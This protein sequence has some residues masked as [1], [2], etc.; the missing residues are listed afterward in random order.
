MYVAKIQG[1]YYLKRKP[2]TGHTHDP[3]CDSFAMP[4]ELS[5][6]GQV[7]GKAITTDDSGETTL[8]LDFPLSVRG[9]RGVAPD[10]GDH[11]PTVAETSPSKLGLLREIGD[12]LVFARL[13]PNG[14]LGRILGRSRFIASGWD[15]F[16]HCLV[17]APTRAG[18]GVGY[19][20]P[21]TLLFPGNCVIL[22]VKG[23]IFE[24][25][26]R[27]RQRQG[28][29]IFYFAPFD[30]EHASHRYNPLERIAA[31]ANPDQQFTELSKLASYFLTTSEKG[32]AAHFIVG[33]RELFVAGGMLAIERGK[34][35]IGEITR[36][37]FGG[38]DKTEEYLARADKLRHRQ[39]RVSVFPTRGSRSR[40]NPRFPGTSAML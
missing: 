10:A 33:A 21:N 20:I 29:E 31:L 5:G 24:A 16:P 4:P 30:F 35:T 12:G 7:E 38:A 15:K 28:D 17:V 23:E 18:K 9:R 34:P 11:E 19:V 6:L 22:D 32:G 8:K 1:E 40:G 26:S 37:L 13:G 3:S 2:G 27:H 39:A 36:V 25:T 14:I